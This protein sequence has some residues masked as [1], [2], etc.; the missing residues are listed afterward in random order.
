MVLEIGS[1]CGLSTIC[2]AQTAARV[3]AADTF[4][5][6]ATP[7]PGDTLEEFWGNVSR[8][9]LTHRV[10]VCR[11]ESAAVEIPEPVDL[12][13]IDGDHDYQAVLADLAVARRHLKPGGLVAFHDYRTSPDE[14]GRWN[15]GVT[16]AV[17][18]LLNADG[19]LIERAGSVAVVSLGNPPRYLKRRE[20]PVVTR[21]R[22]EEQIGIFER[23]QRNALVAYN[24]AEGGLRLCRLWLAE[25]ANEEAMRA[26]AERLVAERGGIPPGLEQTTNGE[27]AEAGA[28]GH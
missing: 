23:D 27:R 8:H 17:D 10:T 28:D 15:P 20:R 13:F 25:L 22:L 16:R 26:Q 5:G 11:G 18:C 21:A 6:R 14:A 12:A 2:M 4:D 19:A 9:G 24:M 3:Y 7:L 1:F